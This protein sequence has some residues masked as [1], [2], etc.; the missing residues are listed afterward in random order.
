[1]ATKASIEQFDQ[2]DFAE[3]QDRLHFF[4]FANNI[5]TVPSGASAA[6]KELA[7]KKE[8][9]YL[10]SLLSKTAYTTLRTL[11]LPAEV[12][13]KKFTDL[14]K[15]LSKH[16]K[17]EKSSTTATFEFRQCVQ[18]VSE[19]C[20]EFSHRLQRLAGDC[21]FDAF[22]DRALKDQ[23]LT[24]L[25]RVD[26]KKKILTSP[27]DQ[28]FSFSD[29]FQI[30]LAEE[31]ADKFVEQLQSS[32]PTTETENKVQCPGFK[33]K[34]A[35]RLRH[36]TTNTRR[37]YRCNFDVHLADKCPHQSTTCGYCKKLSHLERVCRAK[38]RRRVHMVDQDDPL[39]SSGE[40][41]SDFEFTEESI[42]VRKSGGPKSFRPP[43]TVLAE[44]NHSPLNLKFEID[45]G[46]AVNLISIAD[47]EKIRISSF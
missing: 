13:D 34:S 35:P 19:S 9:A 23:F 21:K 24:S 3:Y 43:Y 4:L 46:N 6:Q 28:S 10:V 12:K 7:D 18:G 39:S 1:M 8:A 15:P 38:Q 5:G 47:F 2:G 42:H 33:G 20:T 37:C 16:F 44:V 45:T 32:L 11:C 29:V 14:C 36:P 31:R 40:I 30:A 17:V 27:A 41:D 25:H 26:M 22:L